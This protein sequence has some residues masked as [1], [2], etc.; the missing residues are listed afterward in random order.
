MKNDR[1]YSATMTLASPTAVA[2]FVNEFCGQISD[3][4]WENSGPRDHWKFWCH[5]NVELGVRSEM[6][7][8]NGLCKKNGYNF[9]A[10]IPIVGDRMLANGRMAKAMSNLGLDPANREIVSAGEYMPTTLSDFENC[11]AMGK[12]PYDF[13]A[14]H[15][16]DVTHALAAVFYATT[17]TLKDLRADIKMIKSA[18][19]TVARTAY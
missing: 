13:V 2:L 9:A 3:G 15:M 5:V 17:Y 10:L 1:N 8:V 12:W 4:M 18:M 6:K 7:D 16:N 19:K 14:R 11:K